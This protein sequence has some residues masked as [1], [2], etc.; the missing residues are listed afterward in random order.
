MPR[1]K[2][3]E[4]AKIYIKPSTGWILFEEKLGDRGAS[5]IT[6]IHVDNILGFEETVWPKNETRPEEIRGVHIIYGSMNAVEKLNII[7][8]AEDLQKAIKL[9]KIGRVSE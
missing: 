4:K 2:E 5:K 7:G 9:A 3:I 1:Q 8:S 6:W